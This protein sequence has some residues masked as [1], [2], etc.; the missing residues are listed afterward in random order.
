MILGHVHAH[1]AEQCPPG[2]GSFDFSLLNIASPQ[3]RDS[4]DRL[5]TDHAVGRNWEAHEAALQLAYEHQCHAIIVQEPSKA[6][7]E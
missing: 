6:D 7:H 3:E 4:A 5:P 2:Q 1:Q